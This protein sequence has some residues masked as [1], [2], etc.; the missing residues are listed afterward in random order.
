MCLSNV[1][2]LS[3]AP[4][5]AVR[6]RSGPPIK[7][8]QPAVSYVVLE[9]RSSRIKDCEELLDR[10]LRSIASTV[11]NTQLAIRSHHGIWKARYRTQKPILNTQP[12]GPPG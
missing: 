11:A 2:A 7:A 10:V 4:R 8:S 12:A 3:T 6:A 9:F 5:K 1:T